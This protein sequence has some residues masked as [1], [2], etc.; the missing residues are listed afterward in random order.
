MKLP[1]I[2][3]LTLGC[4]SLASAWTHSPTQ[5]IEEIAPGSASC[6][7]GNAECRTAKQ[8]APFIFKS[9]RRYNLNCP[10]QMAAVI[11]LMAF[12]SVDFAY[13]RNQYP[14]RPGQGT[15]N[16]QMAEFNLE[17]AKSIDDVKDKVANLTSV[18]G[19]PDSEL[20]RV[21]D[22]VVED[23]YNFGSGAWFLSTQC[24]KEVPQKL[25]SDIDAGFED[26]MACV[27]VTVDKS[28]LEYLE[29]A[30]SAF[31]LA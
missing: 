17:Y 11:A 2:A 12:E 23:D 5:I 18:D 4:A 20:N 26:Y 27:G 3:A 9:L 21:L 30:K 10:G 1:T 13:K 15:A 7:Q 24:G 14:G 25:S 6:D 19:L 22:L 16:M 31:N 28:R 29:R 8:A